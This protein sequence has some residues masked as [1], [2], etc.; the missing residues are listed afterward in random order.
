MKS[1][2][3]LRRALP[4]LVLLVLAAGGL[5]AWRALQPAPLPPGLNHANGRL[6]ATEVDVATK[7]AGRLA[8]LL[9]REGD[10]VQAGQEV[11]SLDLA[12]LQAQ[13]A[14]AQAQYAQAKQAV[15]QARAGVAQAEGTR[16]LAQA[17]AQRTRELVAKHFVSAQQLD[18]DNSNLQVAQAS[19]TAAR[20]GVRVAEAAAQVAQAGI[21]RVETAIADSHMQA[22][23]SGRVLY[24]LQ[25][26]GVVLGAGGKVLTLLDLGDVYMTVFL[27][28]AEAG[29]LG[30]GD[31]ALIVLDAAPDQVVPA[32]ISFV[33][34][35]AQFT[36]R[37]VET[38]N[39]REKLMFR[40]KVK[41]DAGWL[42]A[43][44]ALVKPGMPGV[45]WVRTDAS[46]PWPAV[47]PKR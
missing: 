3:L 4:W 35:E 45:A 46:T 41:V 40:V 18:R 33:A 30:I 22:P 11:G 44:G 31:E 25:E 36:P 19:V 17:T 43:N 47:L 12:E 32:R 39:E 13:L 38:R 20:E 15:A 27:P 29:K 28:A 23:I 5:Y 10:P 2:S 14:Q 37:E 42:A 16:A 9:P 24:R 26:P 7:Y 34:D 8:I 1:A 6:E 21:V